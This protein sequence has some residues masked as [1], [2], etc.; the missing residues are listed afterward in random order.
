MKLDSSLFRI[1]C[2]EKSGSK[3]KLQKSSVQRKAELAPVLKTS[4]MF[5][6]F[7]IPKLVFSQ[8]FS[9]RGEELVQYNFTNHKLYILPEDFDFNLLLLLC[10]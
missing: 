3:E 9:L 2:G 8:I 6:P 4:A 7:P 10:A 1:G 5:P